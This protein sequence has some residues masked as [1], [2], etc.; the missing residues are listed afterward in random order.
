[1]KSRSCSKT[2]TAERKKFTRG[3]YIYT[4]LDNGSAEIIFHKESGGQHH[5]IG[6]RTF[7]DCDSFSSVNVG[8]E[9][10]VRQYCIKNLL[11]WI[12]PVS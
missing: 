9:S 5:R 7:V 10:C 11:S 3:E 6:E 1:M 4:L 2:E 12:F 8:Q